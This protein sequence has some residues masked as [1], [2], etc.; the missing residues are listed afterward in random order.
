[1]QK[2][3]LKEHPHSFLGFHLTQL[4]RAMQAFLKIL[5]PFIFKGKLYG[6]GATD[7]K[8]PVLAWINAVSAFQALQEVSG[9]RC[10]GGGR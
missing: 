2:A 3:Q 4:G 9:Q 7:N 1:M 6:R 10:L 5:P 8:G